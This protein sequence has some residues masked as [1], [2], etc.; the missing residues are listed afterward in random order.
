MKQQK[1]CKVC[2][3]LKWFKV[4]KNR[5][6]AKKEEHSICQWCRNLINRFKQRQKFVGKPRHV[7]VIEGKV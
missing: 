1:K 5:E 4:P 6:E 3:R 7:A 2:G